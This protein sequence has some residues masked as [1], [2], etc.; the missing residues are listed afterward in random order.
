MRVITELRYFSIRCL[1]GILCVLMWM[2]LSWGKVSGPCSACH[3]M[4]NSQNSSPVAENGGSSQPFEALLIGDCIFCHT[5][6]NTGTNKIPYV[7]STTPP[8]YN[9]GGFRNTL[10]G[11]NFYWVQQTNG[12]RK[13]HNVA[14]IA[15]PDAA[16][17]L[18][19]PG[20]DPNDY[21]SV[22]G[23][24]RPATWT[25][26]LTCA[27]NFGCHGRFDATNSSL[28][29]PIVA[30]LGAHHKNI[31]RTNGTAPATEVWNSYRFLWGIKGTEDPNYEYGNPSPTEHN[32]YYAST[33][34]GDTG[35]INYL[36]GECHGK[37]HWST[38]VGYASPW[39]RHPTDFD[40]NTVASKGYGNYPN[41][42]IFAGK[43]GVTNPHDYF[44]DVPVGNTQGAALPS[45]L[46]TSGDAIVLCLSCHRAHGS[47]YD[48]IL[49]WNYVAWPGIPDDQNGCLACHTNKW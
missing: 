22:T 43:L 7:L 18:T 29:D 20:Y 15:P 3:T 30:I 27:G 33:S 48:Y 9:F 10:A 14:G 2:G 42:N 17:G 5:G 39:L 24:Y 31:T 26:Q 44:A 45:V 12:D 41:V 6:T 8:T 4:H 40:M 38:Y 49:R 47:P 19:P 21:P 32:G 25:Q 13:G 34:A 36:C 1:V 37:F 46:N 28:N 16:L 35:S 23:T 11:G